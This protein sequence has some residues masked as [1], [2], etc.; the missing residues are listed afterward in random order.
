M[1]VPVV[2]VVDVIVVANRDMAAIRAMLMVVLR[3]DGV[4]VL[5][6]TLCAFLEGVPA[7]Q[8]RG[9]GRDGRAAGHENHSQRRPHDI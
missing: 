5:G 8:G 6:H 3:M 9:G 2:Q 1:A 4:I 7:R